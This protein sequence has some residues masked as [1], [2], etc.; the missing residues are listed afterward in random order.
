MLSASHLHFH[1]EVI[2]CILSVDFSVGHC[3]EVPYLPNHTHAHRNPRSQ[4]FLGGRG[5]DVADSDNFLA[6]YSTRNCQPPTALTPLGMTENMDSLNGKNR[7][8]LY[9]P[10]KVHG[11]Q[12]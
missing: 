2:I 11:V 7:Q 6:E 8:K 4:K 9:I 10:P 1:G 12:N 3:C 5:G